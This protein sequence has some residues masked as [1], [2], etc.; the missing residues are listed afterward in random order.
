MMQHTAQQPMKVLILGAQGYVGKHLTAALSAQAWALPVAASRRVAA[1]AGAAGVPVQQCVVDAT[2]GEA[3]AHALAD[4]DA[5]VNCVAGSPRAIVDNALALEHA[6]R[7]VPRRLVHFS[8]MAAYGSVEGLVNE[9]C[10]LSG[11]LGGYSAAKA[12]AEQSLARL[13][14]TVLL[15][16]GCI[17]GPGSPQWTLR[18]A[19]LLRA[20]RLGDLG[21]QG[22]GYSNLVHVDDVAHAALAALRRPGK[23]SAAYN[24]AMRD[25]PDWNGYFLAMAKGLGAVPVARIGACRLKIETRLAA[26]AFKLIEI[27]T[28]KTRWRRELPPAITPALAR[29]WRQDI[30]LDSSAAERDLGLRWRPLREGIPHSLQG[31]A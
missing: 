11:D 24:L 20:H 29:L 18:I 6:L 15:R 9:T 26:P 22:D 23:V 31:V 16:P 5:V 7:R 8:S 19:R 13:P 4:V 25:A 1:S 10:P 21:E 28:R 2:D 3:L 12:R 14:D 27:A 30:R 17:Y